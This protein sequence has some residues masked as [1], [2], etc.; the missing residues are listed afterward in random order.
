MEPNEHHD[1]MAEA[2]KLE[3]ILRGLKVKNFLLRAEVRRL[4]TLLE[5]LE[6]EDCEKPSKRAASLEHKMFDRMNPI[7]YTLIH[8]EC[9]SVSADSDR[10]DALAGWSME[11]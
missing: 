2:T 4:K 3:G 11:A 5:V 1:L 9:L 8:Y 10:H 7:G 6:E